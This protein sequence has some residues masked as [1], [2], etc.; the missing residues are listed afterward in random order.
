MEAADI[1]G[2]NELSRWKEAQ[3]GLRV[4]GL[5]G[6]SR[7]AGVWWQFPEPCLRCM[8]SS[9][10][11]KCGRRTRNSGASSVEKLDAVAALS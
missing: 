8:S 4:G 11:A 1:S 5:V 10:E 7:P 3:D 9:V 6:R 2:L